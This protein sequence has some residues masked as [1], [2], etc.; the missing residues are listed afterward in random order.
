MIALLSGLQRSGILVL[1]ALFGLAAV[2]G[3]IEMLR[4]RPTRKGTTYG[5]A[6]VA[7]A[8]IGY[9]MTTRGGA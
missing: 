4:G 9:L 3:A 5:S 6:V 7:V 8:L 2:L 1:A